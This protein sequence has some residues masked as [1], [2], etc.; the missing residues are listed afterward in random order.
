MN[1]EKLYRVLIG[2]VVSE[3]AT[4][5]A[6]NGNQVVF[7]VSKD[8]AKRDIKIAVETLFK[9][10]VESVRVLNRKGKTKRTRYGV[11]KQSDTRK[12][13]VR[14]AEGQDI[15]FESLGS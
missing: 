8:A 15:D 11:G 13:Y 3:K 4:M 9:V 6:E 2:P 12:A 10:T 14:L 7:K 5:A 1:Q